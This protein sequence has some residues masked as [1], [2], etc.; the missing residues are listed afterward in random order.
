MKSFDSTFATP[1]AN[2][3][4]DEAL[5]DLCEQHGTEVLRFWESPVPFVVVGYG[6]RIA[7]EVNVPACA[8]RGVPIL[9]RC[10]GGGTVVQGPGC[11]NYAVTLR[12][13]EGDEFATV[14]GTNRFVMER[15]RAAL[16]ALMGKS[17]SVEGCTDLAFHDESHLMKFSGNAQRRR[18]NAILF[19]GTILHA[20][21][22]TLVSELL[23]T[24]SKQPDYRA[25]REHGA[26]LA[27]VRV[28]TEELKLALTS[29]WNVDEPLLNPPFAEIEDLA[30]HRYDTR[31]WN[32]D[33]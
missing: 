19:H 7:A 4:A 12:A 1:A 14:T 29:A 23:K 26:F 5:L 11:L 18:R 16:E 21:D 24:P 3:A 25:A 33:R 6:N 20:F 17:M 15:N 22:L 8:A 2:L 32:A 10:S 27:N 30:R 13:D 31:A 28:T 9:R